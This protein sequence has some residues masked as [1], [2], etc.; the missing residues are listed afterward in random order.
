MAI[1]S[2]ESCGIAL[3]T[4]LVQLLLHVYWLIISRVIWSSKNLWVQPLIIMVLRK[5]NK[6]INEAGLADLKLNGPE[7]TWSNSDAGEHSTEGR[8]L[9]LGN[10]FVS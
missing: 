4:F 3:W 6:C 10:A 9:Y 7:L 8:V 5:L 2:V 1:F